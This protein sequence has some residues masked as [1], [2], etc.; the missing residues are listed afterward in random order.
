M[1]RTIL[2]FAAALALAACSDRRGPTVGN[3]PMAPPA[4]VE[5]FLPAF[6]EEQERILPVL[7]DRRTAQEL[8]DRLNRLF[9]FLKRRDAARAAEE[10]GLIRAAL[11]YYGPSTAVRI[12]DGAELGAIEIVVD[13]AAELLRMTPLPNRAPAER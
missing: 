2:V 8:D 13:R 9:T 4:E 11:R 12:A 3:G 10:V 6:L 5:S 7:E 1:K